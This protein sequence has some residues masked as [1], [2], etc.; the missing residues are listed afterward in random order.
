[1][2]KIKLTRGMVALVDDDDY[3]LVSKYKWHLSKGE[4]TFYARA[5]ISKCDKS[6]VITSMHILIMGS[7]PVLEVDH[8]N[9]NGLDNRRINIRQV[10]HSQN[11]CN[12]FPRRSHSSIYKGVK[13]RKSKSK[14][15]A[16]I[17]HNGKD[18]HIGCFNSQED[19]ALAYNKYAF[20][21]FGEHAY[22]NTVS[23]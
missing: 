21:I 23:R 9:H 5:I 3:G 1:M 7:K 10:T 6:T 19:A 14:W 20:E 17:G 2:K 8:I 22:L 16:Q 18:I 12:R 13:W 11:M 4:H 15:Y